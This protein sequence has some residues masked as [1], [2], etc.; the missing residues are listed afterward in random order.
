[1]VQN[2]IN[3]FTLTETLMKIK[4]SLTVLVGEDANQLEQ[5]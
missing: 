2:E 5:I 4:A 1:M 3:F